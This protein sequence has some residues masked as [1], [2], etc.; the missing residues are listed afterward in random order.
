MKP[1]LKVKALKISQKL[2]GLKLPTNLH[3]HAG[4]ALE[5]ILE[6]DIWASLFD[7]F[8]DPARAWVEC[9]QK[10]GCGLVDE[11]YAVGWLTN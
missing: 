6:D 2:I 8:D 9:E 7:S 10:C 5:Q 1:S 3:G 11:E 4:R